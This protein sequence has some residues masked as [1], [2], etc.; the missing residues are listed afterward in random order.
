MFAVELIMDSG[1]DTEGNWTVA[2]EL[3]PLFG[4]AADGEADKNMIL[5]PRSLVRP[6]DSVAMIVANALLQ[7]SRTVWRGAPSP[8][9]NGLCTGGSS[10]GW[11]W[12][13]GGGGAFR[14]LFS[15]SASWRRSGV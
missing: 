15:G 12:G 8:L 2:A 6:P 9:F 7:S 3:F 1:L 11:W 13:E 5:S 4:I 14:V 10:R